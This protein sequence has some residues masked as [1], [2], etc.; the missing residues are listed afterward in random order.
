MDELGFPAAS[1]RL[2]TGV[3]IPASRRAPS[4]V[5]KSKQ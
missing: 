1:G 2:G 4:Q 3:V 5:Q